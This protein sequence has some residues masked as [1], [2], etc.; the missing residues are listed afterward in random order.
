M[1]EKSFRLE[2]PVFYVLFAVTT[3]VSYLLEFFVHFLPS[4]LEHLHVNVPKLF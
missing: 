2:L 3:L 4:D 1:G